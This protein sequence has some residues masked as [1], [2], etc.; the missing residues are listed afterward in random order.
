MLFE[1]MISVVLLPSNINYLIVVADIAC[2]F[3]ERKHFYQ[4]VVLGAL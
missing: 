3:T 1:H 4:Y 2:S